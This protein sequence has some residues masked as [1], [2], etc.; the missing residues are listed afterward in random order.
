MEGKR[1][2]CED[3]IFREGSAGRS[4]PPV[5]AAVPY[6]E[7]I[8]RP[9]TARRRCVAD[10]GQG[11]AAADCEIAVAPLPRGRGIEFIS[12]IKAGVVPASHIA[13]AEEGVSDALNRGPR[14]LPVTDIQVRLID[15]ACEPSPDAQATFRQAALLAAR[16]AMES[17]DPVVLEP[18]HR[19]SVTVD[20]SSVGDVMGD[21]S[22]RRG[23]LLASS[24]EG[25][26]TTITADVPM[27]ETLGLSSDLIELAG[28]SA[29]HRIERTT[30]QELP[31]SLTEPGPGGGTSQ[32]R[33][34]RRPRPRSGADAISMPRPDRSDDNQPEPADIERIV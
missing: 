16:D 29:T 32:T 31:P 19:L 13:A 33:E 2:Q 28:R 10:R 8:R 18:I 4:I 22:S 23:R 6:T 15:G 12:E 34:P 9:A 30:Y 17:A 26:F 25:P 3:A 27:S 1:R 11:S 24:D 7:T 5:P 14:G 21:L 20:S